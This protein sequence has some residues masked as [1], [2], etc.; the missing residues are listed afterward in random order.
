M[1]FNVII[2]SLKR[3]GTDGNAVYSMDW[4]FLAD[5]A[6]YDLTF[7]SGLFLFKLVSLY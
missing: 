5:D 1:S 4:S 7:F 6:E 2:D 3:Q